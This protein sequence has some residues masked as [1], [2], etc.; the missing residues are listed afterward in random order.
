MGKE[1]QRLWK[2][3]KS[4]L[5]AF[6][7]MVQMLAGIFQT[8]AFV[9][10]L[11]LSMIFCLYSVHSVSS[12]VAELRARVEAQQK[13]IDA[14]RAYAIKLEER[15]AAERKEAGLNTSMDKFWD[16]MMKLGELMRETERS[17]MTRQ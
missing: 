1:E 5:P 14:L 4:F 3:A 13:E 6:T 7:S 2:N 11:F 17:N 10:L 12:E 15:Q 8:V 9:S 16:R